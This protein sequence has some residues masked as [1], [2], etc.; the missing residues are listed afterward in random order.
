MTRRPTPQTPA[1]P[2]ADPASRLRARLH[3]LRHD[4]AGPFGA[5]LPRPRLPGRPEGAAESAGRADPAAVLD[6]AARRLERLAR[7]PRPG[8]AAGAPGPAGGGAALAVSGGDDAAEPDLRT[9]VLVVGGGLAGLAMAAV[10]G[11]A[12]V[13]VLVVDRAPHPA[14]TAAGYDGRTTAISYGTRLVLEG[15]GAWDGMVPHAEPILDIRIADDAF[16]DGALPIHLHFDHREVAERSGGAPF[17]HIV[18]NRMMRLALFDRLDDL[19][20]VDHLAPAD[21]AAIDTDAAGVTA[22]LEDGRTIRAELLIGADG[23]GSF[24]RR[25]AG[26]GT[27]GW[28]YRQTAVV[29]TMEHELPHHGVALEHFMPAGPF[30]VL[31]MTDD[32][33]GRH[34]SSIVWTERPA[35]A[36]QLV[37]MD[38]AAFDA[39]LQAQVGDWLGQVALTGER[40]AYPLGVI[41]A[42]RYT[43]DRIALIGEAA[44]GIHPIAGQG[45]NLGLRDVAALAEG[46]VDAAR[47][48]LD[49]GTADVLCGFERQRRIDNA[50]MIAV[51]DGLNRLFSNAV[52]PIRAARQLGLGAVGRVPPLKRF[53]M[54]Q[55][56]GLAGTGKLPRLLKGEAL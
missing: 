45:L 47:L 37:E 22:T 48:G 41:H 30:A 14:R 44:H 26:I 19:E 16:R 32:P 33:E 13:P 1:A 10:L 15:G 11:T 12:G 46:I 55:A 27:T 49:V 2:A 5:I 52:P 51:T 56:M 9:R 54:E 35:R 3:R 4:P 38:R 53:F 21:V 28:R 7:R 6:R 25:Q 43:A 20:T 18:D 17:G 23:K 50:T 29:C 8:A 40:F 36:K 34:R 42:R 39:A 31:P 24:V